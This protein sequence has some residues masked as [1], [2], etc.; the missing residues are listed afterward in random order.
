M[1]VNYSMLWTVISI[2]IE[3]L[4]RMS[5]QKTS[6]PVRNSEL[7]FSFSKYYMIKFCA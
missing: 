5:M 7:D 2:D 1:N 3:A 4:N 6:I